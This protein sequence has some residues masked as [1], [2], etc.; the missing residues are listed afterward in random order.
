MADK[1][2]YYKVLGVN[3]NATVDEIKKAY[4][5]LARKYHPDLN[6]DDPQSGTKMREL[7]AAYEVLEDK[8]KREHYDKERRKK[9]PLFDI[10]LSYWEN[11]IKYG[12]NFQGKK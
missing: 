7:N 5:K 8:E 11:A 6:P 12:N 2:D 1:K 9:N 3:E 10:D 4:K